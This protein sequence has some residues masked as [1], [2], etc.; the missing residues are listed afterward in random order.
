MRRKTPR[1]RHASGYTEYA[2]Q[3]GLPRHLAQLPGARKGKEEF[4]ALCTY[5]LTGVPPIVVSHEDSQREEN[6]QGS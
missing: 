4:C 6:E 2:R 3:D 5:P 1:V